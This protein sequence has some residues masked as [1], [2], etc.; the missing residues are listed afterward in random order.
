MT[1]FKMVSEL[2]ICYYIYTRYLIHV[3]YCAHL[4]SEK[5]VSYD[6]KF[7]FTN[8][9]LKD[10]IGFL[11]EEMYIYMLYIYVYLKLK[12]IWKQ[13]VF[14]KLLFKLITEC[15]FCDYRKIKRVDSVSMWRTLS[16]IFRLFHE[17]NRKR[18]WITNKTEI[19]RTIPWC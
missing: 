1:A 7:V 17:Q 11:S 5:D 12:P 8:M 3:K 6:K 10:T 15:K 14:K 13:S 16:V 18:R 2:W 19:L 4:W 9:S